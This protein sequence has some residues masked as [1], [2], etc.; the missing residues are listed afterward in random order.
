MCVNFVIYFIYYIY[1][2]LYILVPCPWK[3]F[4]VHPVILCCLDFL[5]LQLCC[6]TTQTVTS[7]GRSTCKRPTRRQPPGLASNRFVVIR[8]PFRIQVDSDNRVMRN[9]PLETDRGGILAN[10]PD[11]IRTVLS[12]DLQNLRKSG[13]PDFPEF[14]SVTIVVFKIIFSMSFL[15][16]PRRNLLYCCEPNAKSGVRVHTPP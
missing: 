3:Y 8:A 12:F 5:K 14:Q 16:K 1:I 9:R 4:S 15:C 6:R 11:F 7:T 13:C 2:L 10:R